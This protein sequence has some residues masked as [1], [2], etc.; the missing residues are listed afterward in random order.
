[1]RLGRALAAFV[2]A[3]GLAAAALPARAA[4]ADPETVAGGRFG[5]VRVMRPAGTMRGLVV[6]YSALS[7]WSDTDQR[8]AELLAQRDVVVVGVDT[9][10]YVATLAGITEACHSLVSDDEAISHQLQREQ[11]SSRYFTP[12][13]AGIAEGGTLAERVLSAAPSNTLAGAISIDPVPIQDARFKPCPPDPTILHDPGLPGFWDVGTTAP[14]PEAT[15]TLVKALQRVDAR[16]VVHDFGKDAA[17]GD[18]L[19]ALVQPHLGPRAPD[20]Q[21]VSDLPLVELPA[22]HIASDV[23]NND[24]KAN[25]YDSNMLAIVI[26]GDGGWRDLD[27]TIA[28]NLQDR[29]VSVVGIDSLRYFW[30]RKT[31]EETA[32]DL[33][34]VI[35]T[36]IRRWHAKSIAL[37]GY[38]FG[39]DVLPFAYNRLPERV[40]ATVTMLSLLG[41][42]PAADFEIRVGGWLGLPPSANA[43]PARPEIAKVPPELVQCF[44]GEDET[45]TLCPTLVTT[46]VA[47]IRTGGSHHFGRDYAHLTQVILNGWRRR[48]TQG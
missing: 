37:I 17:E 25:H 12:I 38:S 28:R 41:F 7:G 29:G 30:R 31:P 44:Y 10:R 32:H 47:V 39:A 16:V 2:T 23:K 4:P 13:L 18:M 45:D 33:A 11:H 40:R 1:M 26:S 9:A 21:D 46:G 35:R 3:V 14:L 42:A 22:S 20:E 27:Q 6:L 19:L 15:Q 36:Y 24:S 8:A 43:L 34:R 48:M 5:E